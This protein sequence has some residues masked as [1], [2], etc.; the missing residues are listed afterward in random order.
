[1]SLDGS[2]AE[3]MVENGAAVA[4]QITETGDV[5]GNTLLVQVDLE[6][7]SFLEKAVHARDVFSRGWSAISL[8]CL[9]LCLGSCRRLAG[10]AGPGQNGSQLKHDDRAQRAH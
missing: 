7:L 4:L 6:E 3:K 9:G 10:L 8:S 5:A 1:M 2:L